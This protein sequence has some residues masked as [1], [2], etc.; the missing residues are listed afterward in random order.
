MVDEH[1]AIDP[2]YTLRGGADQN[3]EGYFT[4]AL[5]DPGKLLVVADQDG[6]VEGYLLA[7]LRAMPP[8]FQPLTIGLIN[9]LVVSLSMRRR[10][11]ARALF[12]FARQWLLRNGATQVEV[13]T[14]T[15]NPNANAFWRSVGFESFAVELRQ[16]LPLATT[17]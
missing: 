3:A 4:T 12:S 7:S 9:E 5:A 1:A 17:A 11:F 8:V 6:C 15:G 2:M 16:T 14:L 13:R 10:G